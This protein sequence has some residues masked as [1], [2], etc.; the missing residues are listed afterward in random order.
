MFDKLT[1]ALLDLTVRERG[2][3]GRGLAL[4]AFPTCCSI[5]ISLCSSSSCSSR[6]GR[7]ILPVLSM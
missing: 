1:E 6:F 5:A 2:R 7:A 3:D 4:V